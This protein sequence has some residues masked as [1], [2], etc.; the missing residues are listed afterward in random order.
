MQLRRSDAELSKSTSSNH[1]D[2][3]HPHKLS[4]W[5]SSASLSLNIRSSIH[6][7]SHNYASIE[8]TLAPSSCFRRGELWL[9]DPSRWTG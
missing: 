2:D 4:A 6:R 8:N 3:R 9:A 5:F 7:D 1:A